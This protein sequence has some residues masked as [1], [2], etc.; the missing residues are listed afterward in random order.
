[1]ML[2]FRARNVAVLVVMTCLVAACSR[3]Q[4]DWRSAEAT[5]TVD[6]YGRFMQQHP[7]SELVTQARTRVAQLQEDLEW[8]RVS[9]TDTPEAYRQF[10]TEH[11]S[12]KWT[13]EARIRLQNFS[14]GADGRSAI[15]ATPPDAATV[16]AP[17][18]PRS[19]ASAARQGPALPAPPGGDQTPTLSRAPAAD[20][21]G[22]YGI[23]LGAFAS[24]G[25]ANAQWQQL[26]TRFGSEL[27]GLAPRVVPV[28]T[29]NGPLF[30]LQAQVNGESQ[31]RALC[32]TLKKQSQPCVPVLPR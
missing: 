25:A 17:D 32:D 22:G 29:A 24:D 4:E 14:L 16:V 13:Q 3:E 27:H 5:D 21:T 10:L 30:R 8:Q 18:P 7:E 28:S 23:Q 1:M 2:T 6:G 26:V 12:G 11:P 19:E 20:P 15:Q 31:A 9:T